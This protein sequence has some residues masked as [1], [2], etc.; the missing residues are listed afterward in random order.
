MGLSDNLTCRKCGSEEETSVH[1]LCEYEALAL[2][3]HI[4][5]GPFSLNPEDIRVLG[6]GAI[7]N[8]VK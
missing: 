5:L 1:I 6:M 8:F 7:W 3:R 4:Y 2:L